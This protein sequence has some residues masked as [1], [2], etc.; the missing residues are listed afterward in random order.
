MFLTYSFEE[1]IPV[2]FDYRFDN[3]SIDISQPNTHLGS[4]Y[5]QQRQNSDIL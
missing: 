3:P 1:Q 4:Q 5:E 2:S